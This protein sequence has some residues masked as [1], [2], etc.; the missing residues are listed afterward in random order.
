MEARVAA[1]A[2]VHS[3]LAGNRWRG[4]DLRKVVEEELAVFPG[5]AVMVTGPAV[6]LR[7]EAAQ[8]MAMVLHELA[9]NAAKHGAL[10]RTGGRLDVS[11]C[12]GPDGE[13]QVRWDE[14]GGPEIREAP[15]QL[16]FGSTLI[17]TMMHAQLGGHVEH[18]WREEGLLCELA[19]APDRLS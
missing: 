4:T 12:L 18:V 5:G 11:W 2:R 16:G 1:L 6:H 7:A 3:L 15:E 10:S 19:V 9:T 8:P 17:E 13:L 14:T